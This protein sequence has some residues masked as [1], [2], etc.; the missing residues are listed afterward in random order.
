MKTSYS[1]AKTVEKALRLLEIVRFEQPVRPVSLAHQLGLTRSNVHRLLA[2]LE[3]L[4]Y[5][6]KD[7]SA[8]RLGL[9][10]F[11][12][13]S[14]VVQRDELLDAARDYMV[15]LSEF[16]N[17]NVNLGVRLE[18]EVVYLNKVERPHLLKLDQT[19]GGT[20]P[21]YCTALG[22][23]L[24]AGLDSHSLSKYLKGQ[25][26]VGRTSKTITTPK[27][28]LSHIEQVRRQGYAVDLEELSFGIHCIAAPIRNHNS[29]TIAAVSVSAPSIR[30]TKSKLP[31]V[32]DK[33][34][35]TA[36]DISLRLG[37]QSQE[38]RG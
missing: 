26:L 24:L 21:L 33:L 15:T 5:V 19:L 22:K 3:A 14:G 31:G 10:A 28:L 38:K 12:L 9:K 36:M 13:G 16:A 17:E 30:L 18:N 34:L 35:R 6:E 20:D 29:Q 7:G 23:V 27:S 4:S 37:F 25:K 32:R 2:T 8:Y 1:P 11:V